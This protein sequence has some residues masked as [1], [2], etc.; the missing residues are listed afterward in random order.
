[1]KQNLF[2]ELE[3]TASTNVQLVVGQSDLRDIL[4]ELITDALDEFKQ[5]SKSETLLSIDEVA[6]KL[7]VT[8]PTLW[9]WAKSNYLV[10]IK[11]GKRPMYKLTDV[12]HLLERKAI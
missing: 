11:V 2:K 4:K 12:E 1:M 6:Q 7:N 3:N 9:R 5:D 10:P 8:K